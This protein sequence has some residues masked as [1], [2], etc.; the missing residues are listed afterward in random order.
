MQKSENSGYLDVMKIS[1]GVLLNLNVKV[2]ICIDINDM[3][4]DYIA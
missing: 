3:L 1:K 4:R 2:Y